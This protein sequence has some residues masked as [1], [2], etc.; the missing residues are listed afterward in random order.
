[1]VRDAGGLDYQ[2]QILINHEA[3][4]SALVTSAADVI[5]TSRVV[6]SPLI[7][8]ESGANRRWLRRKLT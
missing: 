1:M 5:Y 2:A 3:R 4:Q 8:G 7:G 6:N